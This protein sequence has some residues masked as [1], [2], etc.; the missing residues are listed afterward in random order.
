[1]GMVLPFY[2]PRFPASRFRT[3]GWNEEGGRKRLKAE[4]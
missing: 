2:L 4:N 3:G 1:V